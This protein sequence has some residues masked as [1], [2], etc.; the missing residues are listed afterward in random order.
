MLGAFH[1]VSIRGLKQH[2]FSIESYSVMSS[3]LGTELM[4]KRVG[5]TIEG[6]VAVVLKDKIST[7][8]VGVG[9]GVQFRDQDNRGTFFAT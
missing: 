4:R 6:A 2:L 7:E 3:P 8:G 5:Q 9:V 1:G